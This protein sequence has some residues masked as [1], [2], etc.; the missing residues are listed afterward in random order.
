MLDEKIPRFSFQFAS[1]NWMHIYIVDIQFSYS[2]NLVV[3]FDERNEL[4]EYFCFP[5]TVWSYFKLNL[6]K[7][8]FSALMISTL[9]MINL[10]QNVKVIKIVI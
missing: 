1:Y 3:S 5:F 7:N 8:N 4:P 10:F 2:T 6:Y 9:S